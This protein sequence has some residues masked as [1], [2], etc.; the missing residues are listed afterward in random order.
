M[1][2]RDLDGDLP[3]ACAQGR[4]DEQQGQSNQEGVEQMGGP[5]IRYDL[6][7]FW[8]DLNLG[9]ARRLLLASFFISRLSL[10]PNEMHELVLDLLSPSDDLHGVVIPHNE[11]ALLREEGGELMFSCPLEI[12]HCRQDLNSKTVL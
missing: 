7:A 8:I 5:L 4:G 12:V 2:H 6:A 10:T 11:Q 9:D 3:E 1:I